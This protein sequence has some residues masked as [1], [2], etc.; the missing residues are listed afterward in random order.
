MCAAASY[1]A[2]LCGKQ[3]RGGKR[4]GR[5]EGTKRKELMKGGNETKKEGKEVAEEE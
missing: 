1:E 5:I 2:Y 3:K 4:E